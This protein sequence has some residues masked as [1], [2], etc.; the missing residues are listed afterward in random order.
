MGQLDFVILHLFF[1]GCA[2]QRI[3]HPQ[4]IRLLH[5]GGQIFRLD[6][7]VVAQYDGALND[8]LQFPDVSRPLVF[9][10]QRHRRRRNSGVRSL[11]EPGV[12]LQKMLGQL[13][14]IFRVI[15]EWR[16]I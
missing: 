2:G 12:L 1:E 10:Q 9:Q 15:A 4:Q 6:G 13:R 11:I 3:P 14:N 7:V 5:R 16:A 8:I